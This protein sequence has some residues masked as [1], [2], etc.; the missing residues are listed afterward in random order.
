[1]QT[2]LGEIEL[3]LPEAELVLGAG[4]LS[5]EG[6]ELGAEEDG[7]GVHAIGGRTWDLSMAG[8]SHGGSD[9]PSGRW[10]REDQDAHRATTAQPART[11][12]ADDHDPRAHRQPT[13]ATRTDPGKHSQASYLRSRVLILGPGFASLSRRRRQSRGAGCP[14]VPILLTLPPS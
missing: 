1:M 12:T 8:D 3:E 9:D 10:P 14:T 4:E 2:F 7:V 6:G 5:A 13:P 11:A